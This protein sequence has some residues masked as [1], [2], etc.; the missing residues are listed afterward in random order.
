MRLTGRGCCQILESRDNGRG[1]C[2]RRRMRSETPGQGVEDL[3]NLRFNSTRGGL[4]RV[5]TRVNTRL[6]GID[7]VIE[8]GFLL[9]ESRVDTFE[10]LP[11]LLY[12]RIVVTP[13]ISHLL[14]MNLLHLGK[15]GFRLLFH[16]GCERDSQLL[17]PFVKLRYSECGL[18]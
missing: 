14:V 18:W 8:E 4:R 12:L 2:C 13:E 15:P 11:E 3:I 16:L 6:E 10:L 17:E 7:T 1:G 5:E 9:L